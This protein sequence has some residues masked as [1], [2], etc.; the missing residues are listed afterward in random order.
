MLINVPMTS[1]MELIRIQEV[2]QIHEG[3]QFYIASW[4]HVYSE[5]NWSY[6]SY[7]VLLVIR[8]NGCRACVESVKRTN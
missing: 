6:G 3:S 8:A 4:N 5:L 7:M 2:S 1:L